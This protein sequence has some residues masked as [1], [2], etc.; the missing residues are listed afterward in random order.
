MDVVQRYIVVSSLFGGKKFA[1]FLKGERPL[2]LRR[3]SSQQ[4]LGTEFLRREKKLAK[5][6]AMCLMAKCFVCTIG[7]GSCDEY[8]MYESIDDAYSRAEESVSDNKN[9]YCFCLFFSEN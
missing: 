6:M 1:C 5:T 8:H 7:N 2:Q 9:C 4:L 3:S